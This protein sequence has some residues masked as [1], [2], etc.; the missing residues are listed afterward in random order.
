MGLS[1]DGEPGRDGRSDGD[2][3]PNGRVMIGILGHFS[4]CCFA[5]ALSNPCFL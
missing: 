5:E 2:G 3:G 1:G 4:I